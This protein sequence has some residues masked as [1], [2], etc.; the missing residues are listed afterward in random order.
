MMKQ[1]FRV[2]GVAFFLA[3]VSPLMWAQ[4]ISFP[5]KP[6]TIIVPYAPGGVTDSLSRIFAQKLSEQFGKP[7]TVENKAGAGGN[8]GTDF[9]ARATPDG[10]TIVMMIDTNTIAPR[11]IRQT[12]L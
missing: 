4:P 12:Q 9:V 6:I 1:I 2:F 3:L 10:Y 7:V 11:A 8:I 5:S